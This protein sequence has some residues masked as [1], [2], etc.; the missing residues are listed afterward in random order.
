MLMFVG[1][2]DYYDYVAEFYEEGEHPMTGGVCVDGKGYLHFALM[3]TGYSSYVGVLAHELTHGC[4]G[5][6]PLPAWLNEAL[7]M[8]MEEAAC[9]T[10][11]GHFDA[12]EHEKHRA[13]WNQDTIQE[14]W[15]GASWNNAD[16]GFELGY[17]LASLL[18]RKIEVALNPSRESI[19]QF[20]NEATMEDAG[21]AACQK[22]FG[23]SLGE[24]ASSYLGPGD[25]EPK[26]ETWAKQE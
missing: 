8:R 3:L 21:D 10:S 11:S 13:W 19:I 12:E 20:I 5:H 16:D 9:G 18:W 23:I 17:S 2:D 1:V 14:F 6:L 24:L 25:W 7:A 26:T 4:L 22:H 15:S